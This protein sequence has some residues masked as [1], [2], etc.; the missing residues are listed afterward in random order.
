MRFRQ[1][2][3]HCRRFLEAA[4]PTFTDNTKV[5]HFPKALR[6]YNKLLL[7]FSARVNFLYI[8]CLTA[9]KCYLLFMIKQNCLQKT[10]LRNHILMTQVSS[11]FYSKTNLKLHDIHITP[12]LVKKVIDNLNLP[13]AIV[14]I[15]WF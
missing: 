8:L 13:K 2:R 14:F 7:V 11:V 3:N 12:N 6:N 1:I 4:K 10:F 5:Y 9:L 15:W